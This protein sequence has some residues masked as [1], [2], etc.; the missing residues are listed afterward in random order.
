MS[1]V[2]GTS[3]IYMWASQY[4]N[5]LSQKFEYREDHCIYNYL[6]VKKINQ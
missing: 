3:N 2:R 1:I 4:Q 6:I 5:V